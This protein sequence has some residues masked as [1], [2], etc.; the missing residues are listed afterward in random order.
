MTLYYANL[1]I[2]LSKNSFVSLSIEIW[3]EYNIS[4]IRTN[5]ILGITIYIWA[6]QYT[7]LSTSARGTFKNPKTFSEWISHTYTSEISSDE[8]F[9]RCELVMPIR[10]GQWGCLTNGNRNHAPEKL[11]D[12]SSR[13]FPAFGKL[14]WTRGRRL[15]RL[16]SQSSTEM[17]RNFHTDYI[18]GKAGKAVHRS[19]VR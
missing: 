2:F 14:P 7:H 18:V 19:S 12:F 3:F 13:H 17:N 6:Q 11:Y 8:I 16:P 9:P 15:I 1:K 10:R 4:K 5:S